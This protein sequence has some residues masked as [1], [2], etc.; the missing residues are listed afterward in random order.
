M[1]DRMRRSINDVLLRRVRSEGT[2]SRDDANDDNHVSIAAS[3]SSAPPAPD[4]PVVI[5]TFRRSGS[6]IRRSF[7]R[8]LGLNPDPRER[9][10]RSTSLLEHILRRGQTRDSATEPF[11]PFPEYTSEPAAPIGDR[12]TDRRTSS[13]TYVNSLYGSIHPAQQRRASQGMANVHSDGDNIGGSY[14]NG[15]YDHTLH[16]QHHMANEEGPQQPTYTG[17]QLFGPDVQTGAPAEFY[18]IPGQ[19]GETPRGARDPN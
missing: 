3:T 16:Q 1:T 11:P 14:A 12:G 9:R 5:S 2:R 8:R 19:V 18:N 13:G 15:P 10:L 17:P 4:Q 7:R 6:R